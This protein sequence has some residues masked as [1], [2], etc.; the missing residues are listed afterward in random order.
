MSTS[1]DMSS[2]LSM[3]IKVLSSSEL[4]RLSSSHMAIVIMCGATLMLCVC[5][6]VCSYVVSTF[7]YCTKRGAILKIRLVNS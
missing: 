6:V 4:I 7:G 5:T 2:F 3:L 1:Y